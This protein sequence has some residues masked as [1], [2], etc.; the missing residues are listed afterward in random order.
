MGL[1]EGA[2]LPMS[3]DSD[4][5]RVALET[6]GYVLEAPIGHGAAAIVYRAH[7]VRHDRAVAIKVLHAEGNSRDSVERFAREIRI[8]ARL[9]HPHILPVHDS[10]EVAGTFFYVMPYVSESLRNRLDRGIR[11]EVAEAVRIAGQLADA[12]DYAHGQG[13]L[14][15]D[16]KPENIL[17]EGSHVAL[18]DFGVARG[19]GNSPWRSLTATGYIVGTLAYM[20]PEQFAGEN[21]VDA[22]SDIFSLGCVLFEML[23]GTSY[24]IGDDGHVDFSRRFIDRPIGLRK[25]NP[26]ASEALEQVLAQALACSPDR[27]FASAR[28]LAC[29]LLDPG[30]SPVFTRRP[31]FPTTADVIIG[32]ESEL[33]ALESLLERSRLVTV[34]GAGGVGKTHLSLF[35]ARRWQA[36]APG[37]C[38]VVPLAGVDERFLPTTI[39]ET[40]GFTFGGWRDPTEQLIDHLRDKRLLLVLDNFEH[41][42]SAAPFLANL[43]AHTTDVRYL[44]TSRERLALRD[45]TVF[46]IGGL[47]LTPE[48][49]SAE[50]SDA[51][52]LFLHA[53]ARVRP[54]FRPTPSD[55]TSI[56]RICRLLDGMPLGIEMAAALLRVLECEGIVLELERSFDALEAGVRDVPDRHRTL[57]AVF[58]YSWNLI[59]EEQREGLCRLALFRGEFDHDAARE[60]ADVSLHVLAALTDASLLRRA[61]S[62][63]LV[64]HPVFRQYAEEHLRERSDAARLATDRYIRFFARLM[65][66]RGQA[67]RSSSHASAI[68]AIADEIADFRAAW[69]AAVA[70]SDE[71]ALRDLVDGLFQVYDLR[72]W[73]REGQVVID[74]A[75]TRASLSTFMLAKLLAYRARFSFQLSQFSDALELAR[76]SHRHFQALGAEREAADALLHQARVHFRGGRFDEAE[77]AITRALQAYAS[78]DAL[79]ER[80]MALDDLGCV[81][82][83][84]GRTS[85]AEEALRVSLALFQQAGNLWGEAKVL[86]NLGGVLDGPNRHAESMALFERALRIN[87]RL[88]DRR[89]LSV[90]LHNVARCAHL[91]GNASQARSCAEA[92]LE[93]ARDLG[94]PLDISTTLGLLGEIETYAERFEEAFRCYQEALAIA[95]TVG[96]DSLALQHVLDIGRLLLH[97]GYPAA[98]IEPLSLAAS[99]PAVDRRSRDVASQMLADALARIPQ[100]QRLAESE[101]PRDLKAFAVRFDAEVARRLWSRPPAMRLGHGRDASQTDTRV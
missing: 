23:T 83:V 56:H 32:R 79:H 93:I 92:S 7:D 3:M 70:S 21:D 24:F 18:A 16:I 98:A 40:L 57:R 14:H 20:S 31:I 100:S 27:R 71:T 81:L 38:A 29:A 61:A 68:A 84:Q 35:I 34:L 22:R 28:A 82:A 55:I 42:A 64:I 5:V 54:R 63:R 11:F 97:M 80:A 10:G 52:Q 49:G 43:L 59:E 50:V 15:R 19:L 69:S 45:E 33:A 77:G 41:L 62:G 94:A 2:P 58:E 4:A 86:N 90:S 12:L 8:A 17:I 76:R 88:G 26:D 47:R 53:A 36:R 101:M 46:E 30:M 1:P 25:L 87:Q 48:E 66:S 13:V 91:L 75:M 67:L 95:N 85:D 96:A 44:V 60:V 72:G 89:D 51:A 99:H 39:A 78:D 37:S 6:H 65:R 9:V 73:Y 74:D